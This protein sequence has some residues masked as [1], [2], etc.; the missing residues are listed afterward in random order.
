MA[1]RTYEELQPQSDWVRESGSNT[2]I[3]DLQGFKKEQLKVQLDN[4]GNLKISGERPVTDNRWARFRK[5]FRIPEN[6]N[7][8]E[9][10]AKFEKGTLYV[11][12][13]KTIT[14]T[15]PPL[16][17]SP[18]PTPTQQK[19]A[20]QE[21]TEKKTNEEREQEQKPKP[22]PSPE[23][24][25]KVPSGKEE[26]GPMPPP[27]SGKAAKGGVMQGLMRKK[28]NQLLVNVLVSFAVVVG[29]GI[30]AAYKFKAATGTGERN[31]D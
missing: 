13:P 18:P 22:Q 30:Y 9:I 11:I 19:P 10:R 24:A 8:N 25:R 6:S 28:P 1:N 7:L 4:I 31:Q 16:Q 14:Q 15:L 17:R 20:Q 27:P 23:A 2:L 5:D 21:E 26:M 3:I 29:I 12:I